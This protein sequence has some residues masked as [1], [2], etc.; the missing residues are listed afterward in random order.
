[1]AKPLALPALS[2]DSG[3]RRYMQDIQ[4]FPVLTADEEYALAKRWTDDGDSEAA[5]ALVTSH[6]RL[7]AKIA[8]GYRGY[9]L[10]VAELIAEGNIGLMQAVKKFEPEKGFRL[11]T[12]AMWWIKAS[13]Q[14]FVLRSWSLV[15]MG[16]SA[17]QKRLFFNLRKMKK[18][19]KVVDDAK[20]LSQDEIRLI[21]REL[22]V[23]EQD[24]IDMD[25]R[26]SA[27]DKHLNAR[28]GYDGDSEW[29]DMLADESDSQ[30]TI[31]AEQ[32]DYGQKRMLML[33]AMGTLNERERD[34]I[35]ERQL[36]ENPLTL[37]E[38]SVRYGVSR[39]RVRQIESRAM[40]KM[41][42]YVSRATIEQAEATE[43]RVIA[44]NQ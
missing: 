31:L 9:G 38:L 28:V 2:S 8:M 35:N 40:E 27:N 23:S 21:A 7:V 29:G 15:K 36:S 11:S 14:E 13:I 6:L 17:A 10:P 3:L 41:A 43:R 34:I 5:H 1:M 26:M 39:E 4:K 30:E 24:V 42:S 44:F 32:E 33:D 18:R 37:E 22:D 16:S 19:L 20:S 12:Y 25:S